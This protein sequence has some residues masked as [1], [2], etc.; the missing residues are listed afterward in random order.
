MRDYVLQILTM[1][2]DNAT[3]R[4]KKLPCFIGYDLGIFFTDYTN[5]TYI[6]LNAPTPQTC[7]LC[8]LEYP[9]TLTLW[10]SSLYT[11]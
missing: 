9:C 4:T 5:N 8:M 10:T 11:D 6:W 3:L 1:E 2:L 7:I